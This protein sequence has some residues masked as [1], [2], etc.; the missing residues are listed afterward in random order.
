M[1]EPGVP[2]AEAQAELRDPGL[3]GVRAI[4]AATAAIRQMSSAWE[5]LVTPVW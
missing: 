1:L 3:Q 5:R 4:I 2:A